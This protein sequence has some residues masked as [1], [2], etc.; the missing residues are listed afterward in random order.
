MCERKRRKTK[1]QRTVGHIQAPAL[2]V[3]SEIAH[4]MVYV[5]YSEIAHNMVC[6]IYIT[7]NIYIYIIDITDLLALDGFASKL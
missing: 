5:G 6:G 3:S 1:I 7:C 4:N 2:Q